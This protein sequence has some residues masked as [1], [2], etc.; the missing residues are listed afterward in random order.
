[1][2]AI[3]ILRNG[4]WTVMSEAGVDIDVGVFQRVVGRQGGAGHPRLQLCSPD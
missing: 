3:V 1:M 4:F 2:Y